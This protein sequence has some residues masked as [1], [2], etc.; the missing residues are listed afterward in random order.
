[1]KDEVIRLYLQGKSR[2]DIAR[3]CKLGQ[4]TVLT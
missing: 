1:M 4:G 2:N 3:I